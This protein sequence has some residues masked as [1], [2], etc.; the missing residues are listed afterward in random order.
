MKTSLELG[1]IVFLSNTFLRCWSSLLWRAAV[2]SDHVLPD[3]WLNERWMVR[4]GQLFVQSNE[5]PSHHTRRLSLF[6]LAHF[7]VIQFF[8]I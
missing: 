3:G 2:L 7:Q 4:C 8:L 1:L 5:Y 6:L